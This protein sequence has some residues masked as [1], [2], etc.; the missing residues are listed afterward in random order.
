MEPHLILNSR[1]GS[2]EDYRNVC[3][4][5]E[6]EKNVS[7]ALPYLSGRVMLRSKWGLTGV[8]I[9]GVDTQA[10]RQLIKGFAPLEASNL[11]QNTRAGKN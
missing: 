9:R 5:I 3:K 10:K 6:N 1:T 11:L 4:K 7:E 2:F 8:I